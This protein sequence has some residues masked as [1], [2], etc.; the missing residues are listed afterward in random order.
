MS[1]LH[2]DRI[3]STLEGLFDG[4]IDLDDLKGKSEKDK[5]SAFLSRSLAAYTLANRAKI[6]HRT[7]AKAVTDGYNYNGID[8]IYF[9]RDELLVLCNTNLAN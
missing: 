2:V 6:D 5:K 1:K 4:I 8:A 9:D 7:A 3:S